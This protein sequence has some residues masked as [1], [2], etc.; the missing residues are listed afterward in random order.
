MGAKSN[1]FASDLLRFIFNG[2][3]IAGL[4]SES[5][6]KPLY[7]S[8]HTAAPEAAG[9]Q[10]ANECSYAGY[11][12]ASAVRDKQQFRVTNQAVNLLSAISFPRAGKGKQTATHFGVGTEG[13]K[14]LY[15]GEIKP[16]IVVTEGVVAELDKGTTIA[17]S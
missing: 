9:D 7:F 6:S 15:S 10:S 11:V 14:L 4:S 8:L 2:E 1:A 17:E 13:G 12:R 3:P 5:A 16:A